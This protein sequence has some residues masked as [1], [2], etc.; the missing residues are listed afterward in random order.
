M[1]RHAEEAFA[2]PH[3]ATPGEEETVGT[4]RDQCGHCGSTANQG[5]T[6]AEL[7]MFPGR[8]QGGH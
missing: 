4:S 6:Q 8:E 3:S 1:M 5:S 2:T 7:H